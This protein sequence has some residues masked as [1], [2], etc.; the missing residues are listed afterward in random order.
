[1]A[2]NMWTKLIAT[3]NDAQRLERCL[4]SLSLFS[5]PT[6]VIDA[7]RDNTKQIAEELSV[8]YLSVDWQ[9]NWSSI[10]NAVGSAIQ[11]W[12]IWI[13]PWEEVIELPDP[14]EDP[15]NLSVTLISGNWISYPARAFHSSAPLVF[16]NPTFESAEANSH[17]R[18]VLVGTGGRPASETEKII[19]DWASREPANH[20]VPYYRA[21]HRLSCGDISG[22]RTAAHEYL[23]RD[24]KFSDS[25]TLIKLYL[26]LVESKT[27]PSIAMGW[28]AEALSDK[29][30]LAEAWF[31]SAEICRSAGQLGRAAALYKAAIVFGKHRPNDEKF[32]V[33]ALKYQEEPEKI[34]TAIA[35]LNGKA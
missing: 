34:L 19:S 8:S 5:G 25:G 16:S 26:G 21:M 11:G 1:M 12:S 29:P 23:F 3:R 7:G 28:L 22:F 35:S 32:P 14:P 30:W 6:I 4:K 13:E 24:N 2:K 10:K 20:Q 31:A 27:N 17:S 9:N 15:I 33:D 18:I